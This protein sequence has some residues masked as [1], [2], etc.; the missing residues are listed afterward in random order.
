MGVA[1]WT[2]RLKTRKTYRKRLTSLLE[3]G[4]VKG[5][6]SYSQE[7]QTFCSIQALSCLNETHLL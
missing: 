2:D 1:P 5:V 3:G 6:P 7:G 4:Q